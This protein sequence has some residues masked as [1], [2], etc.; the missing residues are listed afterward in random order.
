M[1]KKIVEIYV[2]MDKK[3]NEA[4]FTFRRCG[5]SK[6]ANAMMCFLAKKINT[7]HVNLNIEEGENDG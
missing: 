5:N 2:E 3:K 1:K 4:N 7:T 6:I